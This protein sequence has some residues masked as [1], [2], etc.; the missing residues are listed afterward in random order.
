MAQNDCSRAGPLGR[1]HVLNPE[2]LAVCH[3]EADRGRGGQSVGVAVERALPQA[4]VLRTYLVHL[5]IIVGLLNL[6]S[7]L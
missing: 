4:L 3:H 5:P 2:H 1:V 7:L 6:L